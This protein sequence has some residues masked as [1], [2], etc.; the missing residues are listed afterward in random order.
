MGKSRIH[1]WWSP[2]ELETEIRLG[3]WA[4]RFYLRRLLSSCRAPWTYVY[5]DRFRA[6]PRYFYECFSSHHL[7]SLSLFNSSTQ[8]CWQVFGPPGTGKTVVVVELLLQLLGL[9]QSSSTMYLYECVSSHPLLSLS[10]P[11]LY[12][13]SARLVRARRW[14]LSSS[15]CSY[16]PRTPTRESWSAL[17]LTPRPMYALYL[18]IYCI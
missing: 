14:L 2:S 9:T 12:R 5:S 7:L 4:K 8:L 18:P 13:S 1:R 17:P 6:N 10:I 11:L 16:S 15:S 3:T